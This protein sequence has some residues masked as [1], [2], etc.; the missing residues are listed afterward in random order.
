[1]MFNIDTTST[2]R[3]RGVRYGYPAVRLK[4]GKGQRRN[5]RTRAALVARNTQAVAQARRLMDIF[6]RRV[7][8]IVE[9]NA[10]R[11]EVEGA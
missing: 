7:R 8:V 9:A 5:R 3:M 4:L 11:Y 10:R 2:V 6:G 1:M